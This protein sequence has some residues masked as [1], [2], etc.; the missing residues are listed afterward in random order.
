M[1]ETENVPDP[2]MLLNTIGV[3]F[4]GVVPTGKVTG[5]IEFEIHRLTFPIILPDEI[6]NDPKLEALVPREKIFVLVNKFPFNKLSVLL[7]AVFALSV[8]PEALLIVKLLT[9]EGNALPVTW[10]E[11]PLYI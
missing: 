5:E 1:A 11:V 7:T 3:Y 10:E 6:I 2:T 8:T 9:V 4:V